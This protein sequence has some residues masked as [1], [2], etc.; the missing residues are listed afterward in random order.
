MMLVTIVMIELPKL[1]LL[2]LKSVK[3][4]EKEVLNHSVILIQ[5]QLTVSK[6]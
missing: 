3:E 2:F 1:I 5:V 4:M 6:I